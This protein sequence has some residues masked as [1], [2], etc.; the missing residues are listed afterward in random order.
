MKACEDPLRI[1][2]ATCDVTSETDVVASVR[3]AVA[4]VNGLDVLVNVAGDPPHDADRATH[5]DDLHLLYEVNLVGTALFCRDVVGRLP[6]GGAI[7]NVVA[8]SAGAHGDPYMPAYSASKGPCSAP[9]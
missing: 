4:E 7:V 8:S 2:T 9:P 1:T 3:A 5:V 6:R